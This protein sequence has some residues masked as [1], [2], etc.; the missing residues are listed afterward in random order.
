MALPVLLSRQWT[1]LRSDWRNFLI[2]LGQPPIIAA[3]VC[4]VVTDK[5]SQPRDLIMFFAYLSTL[6]FGTSNAAQE[7]VKEIAIYRR[8]RLIGVGAHPYLLSK[9]IFLGLITCLQSSVLYLLMIAF[10]GNRDGSM[11]VQLGGLCSTAVAAVGI[12]CAISALARTVMQA[13]MIVPLVLIPMIIFSGFVVKPSEMSKAVRVASLCTPGYAAQMMM[14]TSFVYRRPWEEVRDNSHRTSMS[15][16]Q[17]V[18]DEA[19]MEDDQ[20]VDKRPVGLALLIHAAW[21]GVTYLIAWFAL[22]RRERQ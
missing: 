20:W 21:A 17:Q 5:A 9:F 22:L 14:D 16:L 6:W 11:L 18:V 10:E 1:I 13:V 8:E 4:W 2:L 15:N 19:K 12:G 7:I 3:L